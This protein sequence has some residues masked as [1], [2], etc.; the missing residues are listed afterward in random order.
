VQPTTAIPTEPVSPAEGTQAPVSEPTKT[1]ET[2]TS[3]QPTTEEREETVMGLRLV[4]KGI[5]AIEYE[6]DWEKTTKKYYEGVYDYDE[7]DVV[8]A[9]VDIA[10][11]SVR[12]QNTRRSQ[13]RRRLDGSVADDRE[14][15]SSDPSVEVTYTQITRYSSKNPDLTINEIVLMPLETGVLRDEYVK[16]LKDLDGSYE[17]VS[18]VS[19]ISISSDSDNSEMPPPPPGG[20]GGLSIGAI[21][22]IVCAGLV[23]V[24]LIAGFVYYQYQRDSDDDDDPG[25]TTLPSSTQDGTRVPSGGAT[26]ASL[27]TYGDTSVA[28]VD[29]DYSRAYG[30]A[31]NHSLSDAGGTLGSRTRQTAA[32]DVASGLTSGTPSMQP[33]GG[34]NTIFS[35]DATFDQAY[36]DVREELLDVY[37]PAGKLGVV[38]DTPDDGAPVVHAVKDSSPIAEKVQVGDKLVAVDDEDV[39]AMTA[40]KVSKLISRKSNNPSRKL[41]IIRH[42][43]NH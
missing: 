12:P 14:L 43:S 20:D 39:R 32:E 10:I 19:E 11:E 25:N 38:I 23:V 7:S 40:I 18:D 42:V 41:T 29:Y 21:I 22:G 33:P 31:G 26:N 4:L 3:E 9:D 37:A 36:E 35:D 2:G 27:P 34:G 13:R 6:R 17:L 28:T 1:P 16:A 15:Q 5:S 24:I 30:G 8:G